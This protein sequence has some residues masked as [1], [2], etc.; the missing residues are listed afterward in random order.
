MATPGK[1]IIGCVA[2]TT[3]EEMKPYHEV[4]ARLIP[5]DVWFDWAGSSASISDSYHEFENQ[6]EGIVRR[7]SQL[8]DEHPDWHG[9]ISRG[10]PPELKNPGLTD[11]LR[12]QINIPVATALGSCVAAIQALSAQR[13]QLM[14]PFDRPMNE[15]LKQ[16][17]STAGIDAI[18]PPAFVQNVDVSTLTPEG[19]FLLTER[20][21]ENKSVDA[22]YFQGASL[23]PLKVIDRI[24]SE[25]GISIV[26][27]NPAMLWS[28]LAQLGKTYHIDGAGQLLSAWPAHP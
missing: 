1:I 22:I 3:A 27:S 25:F 7:V 5:D 20:A 15:L 16:F 9:V 13:V 8:V 14:T 28:I 26:A 19:V 10:A 17:L 2:P 11:R 12:A 24:E 21:L 4:F 6:G 23:D 18:V